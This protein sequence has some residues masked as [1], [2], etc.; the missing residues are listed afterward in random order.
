MNPFAVR[1]MLGLIDPEVLVVAYVNQPIIAPP[2]IGVYNGI[3]AYPLENNLLERFTATI[4]NKLGVNRSAA[5]KYTENRTLSC[6]SAYLVDATLPLMRL[7][8]K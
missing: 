3:H 2:A 6:T 1:E 4:G 8:Q 7:D 5:L